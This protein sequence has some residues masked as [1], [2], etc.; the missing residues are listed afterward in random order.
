VLVL[1]ARHLTGVETADVTGN[2]TDVTHA[3]TSDAAAEAANAATADARHMTDAK[4]A[5]H[6]ATTTAASAA[7]GLCTGR[8]KTPGKHCTCQNHDQSSFH[9]TLHQVGRMFRHRIRQ[10][11]VDSTLGV[12]TSRWNGD[13]NAHNPPQPKFT[14]NKPS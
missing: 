3:E 6:V 10:T 12:S 14:L 8:D 4:A 13:R 9:D 1:N 2:A 11:L 7:T 5:A